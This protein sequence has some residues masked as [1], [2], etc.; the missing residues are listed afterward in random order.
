MLQWNFWN[1][2]QK[3]CGNISIAMKDW[4]DFWN[5]SVI[6]CAMWDVNCTRTWSK[7]VNSDFTKKAFVSFDVYAGAFSWWRNHV[8]SRDLG[9]VFLS[10]SMTFGKHAWLYQKLVTVRCFSTTTLFIIPRFPNNAAIMHFFVEL[11]FRT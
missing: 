3:C 5:V 7:S 2:W 11:N 8:L 6:F 9:L 1:N 10:S 4:K